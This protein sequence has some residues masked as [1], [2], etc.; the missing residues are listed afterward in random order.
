MPQK[1]V[2]EFFTTIYRLTSQNWTLQHPLNSFLFPLSDHLLFASMGHVLAKM[3]LNMLRVVVKC[4]NECFAIKWKQFHQQAI[5]ILPVRWPK[6]VQ[7]DFQYFEYKKNYF[8]LKFVFI[9]Y[10]GK[11]L[12][13]HLVHIANRRQLI[14]EN[15]IMDIMFCRSD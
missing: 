2:S 14:T 11:H 9:T 10:P 1:Q 8:S 6:C 12:C 4:A 7:A 3:D 13:I 5:H 15:S